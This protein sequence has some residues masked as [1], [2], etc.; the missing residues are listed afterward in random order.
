ML[1]MDPFLKVWS[2]FLYEHYKEPDGPKLIGRVL[3][4]STAVVAGAGLSISVL[5][6][7]VLPYISGPEFHSAYIY[8][9]FICLGTVFYSM[10]HITDAGMLI[11]KVTKYKPLIGTVHACIGVGGSCLLIPKYGAM[12]AAIIAV[13]I[14][15]EGLLFSHFISRRYYVFPIE[16]RKLLLIFA[17]CICTYLSS[18]VLVDNAEVLN[19]PELLALVSLALYP[20]ILWIGGF[21]SDSGQAVITDLFVRKTRA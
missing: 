10:H 3:T 2:P 6:P 19:F 4:L 16:M 20:L 14:P 8:L 13:I 5:A 1:I 15:L 21:F 17:A 18:T 12:G 7:F 11:A 9:P